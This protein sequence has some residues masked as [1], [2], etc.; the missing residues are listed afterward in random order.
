MS[1][2]ATTS[3]SLC[4]RNAES[5]WSPRLPMPTNPP[6]TR[7][8]APY[9]RLAESAVA[10]ATVADLAKSRRVMRDMGS[11]RREEKEEPHDQ[12]RKG[13]IQTGRLFSTL[14]SV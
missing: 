8:F 12:R 7:S 10:V 5:T 14:H 4:V 9:T 13:T 2:T 3:Q 1:H 6:R 11:L